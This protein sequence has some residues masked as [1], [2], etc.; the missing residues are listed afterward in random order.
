MSLEKLKHY[1][2][3]NNLFVFTVRC[4]RHSMFCSRQL[5]ARI[6]LNG[7]TVAYK[8]LPSKLKYL[9]ANRSALL[10]MYQ[11]Y[12][13]DYNRYRKHAMIKETAG[14]T[15]S[16]LKSRL[17]MRS[18][19]LEKGLS[20][21]SVKKAF[22]TER[23]RDLDDALSEYTLQ[24]IPISAVEYRQAISSINKYCEFHEK[25]FDLD[26][27]AVHPALSKWISKGDDY[28]IGGTR[29]VYKRDICKS[30]SV[31][32]DEFSKSRY[33]IRQFKSGLIDV[34]RLRKSVQIAQKSPSVCNRQSTRV[35]IVQD[36]KILKSALDI[37]AGSKGFT[38]EIE[39]VLFVLG[40]LSCF[41]GSRER[42]QVFVD[43]GLFA[44]SLLYAL[45]ADGLATCSLNWSACRK[46]DSA[47]RSL[48]I[49]NDSETIIMMIAVG[50][51]KE[52][53][54]VAYSARRDTDDVLRAI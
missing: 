35:L 49:I 24:N 32:F 8:A 7:K 12:S 13:Y 41:T 3:T 18:H 1:W 9:V 15:L 10:E 39:Q 19:S 5:I 20:L 29:I 23:I 33:S 42:N 53:F 31:D 11:D 28:L 40:D 21:S 17:L 30:S 44:M 54:S 6:A 47:L 26:A 34:E 51:M 50:Y 37:Q 45:H 2:Q 43:G 52:Q 36:S 16:Q 38:D 4:I 14:N 27:K 22:G 48:Y 25:I 46:Q